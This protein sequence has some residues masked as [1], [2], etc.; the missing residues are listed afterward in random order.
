MRP[1][2]EG[3]TTILQSLKDEQP[4][5]LAQMEGLSTK[6]IIL[7]AKTSAVASYLSKKYLRQKGSAKWL[8]IAAGVGVAA[9]L[10]MKLKSSK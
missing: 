1:C 3:E 5:E 2:F 8:Y 10:I 9:L 6:K 7:P 4:K